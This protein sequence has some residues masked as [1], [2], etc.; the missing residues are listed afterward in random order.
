[1]D[2]K[3]VA[4][5][6]IIGGG[7]V[8]LLTGYRQRSRDA[9]ISEFGAT[10]SESIAIT[11]CSDKDDIRVGADVEEEQFVRNEQFFGESGQSKIRNCRVIVVGVGGVGSHCAITLARSGVGAIRLIDFDR[12]T[13]SSLNRHASATHDEVGLPKVLSI[14][15]HVQ[16]F[17][18]NCFV[19][20]VEALFNY[21]SAEDLIASFNPDWVVDAIDNIHTKADLLAFCYQRG[22][23][24]VSACG[25]AAKCDPTRIRISTVEGT[26]EDPLARAIRQRLRLSHKLT[27]TGIPVVYSTERTSRGLLPL[28]EFQ[29][30]NPQEYQALDK[31]RVRILPVIAPLPA[32]MGNAIAS[33]ILCEVA[34]QPFTPHTT[35][36]VASVTARKKLWNFLRRYF[37]AYGP[38]L[39]DSPDGEMI[40]DIVHDACAGRSVVSGDSGN[41]CLVPF[42]NQKDGSITPSDIVL[43]TT[44]E[45]K[46]HITD[47][48]FVESER[49][50]KIRSRVC[51]ELEQSGI[52]S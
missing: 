15:R 46:A 38:Q 24:V 3:S 14:R 9:L 29:E 34:E 8:T 27:N 37:P 33:H 4:T 45:A 1:M 35:A 21:D 44:T 5:G 51:K 50:L 41:L 52:V 16:S 6:I 31:F 36:H 48:P 26:S 42:F 32:I 43:M 13:V 47:T 12:V 18:P 40:L 19:D 10:L 30:E 7:L 23:K 11:N 20:P 25:S 49:I 22:I 17:A 2:F 28:K 39:A